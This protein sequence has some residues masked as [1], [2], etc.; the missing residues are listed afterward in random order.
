MGG[1]EARMSLSDV[2]LLS[3]MA[4][5]MHRAVRATRAATAIKALRHSHRQE[6][7]AFARARR[8]R[9]PLTVEGY[10]FANPAHA[11]AVTG[12][13]AEPPVQVS[14]LQAGAGLPDLR[15]RLVSNA[16]GVPLFHLDVRQLQAALR[17]EAGRYLDATVSATVGAG[18]FNQASRPAL[19]RREPVIEEVPLAVA[20]HRDE[21]GGDAAG[22][23]GATG[24]TAAEGGGDGGAGGGGWGQGGEKKKRGVMEAQLSLPEVMDV[25]V[26]HAMVSAVRRKA[27]ALSKDRVTT[28]ARIRQPFRM[29]NRCGEAL[30]LTVRRS[31][32]MT[33]TAAAAKEELR[34]TLADGGEDTV[35][36]GSLPAEQQPPAAGGGDVS[37]PGTPARS[38]S[39]A[40]TASPS[41]LQQVQAPCWE[42]IAS[43]GMSERRHSLMVAMRHRGCLYVS[44]H[45]CP[46]DTAGAHSMR[47]RRM[48]GSTPRARSTFEA[49][50]GGG[51]G[52]GG[53]R[54]KSPAA[55]LF[56]VAEVSVDDDGTRVLTVRTR[57][58]IENS[59]GV[60]VRLSLGRP[61]GARVERDLDAGATAHVPLSLLEPDLEIHARPTASAGAPS[62]WATLV[63]SLAGAEKTAYAAPKVK[64]APTSAGG[65]GRAG[66]QGSGGGGGGDGGE[67]KVFAASS[68]P[69]PGASRGVRG[70]AGAGAL[71]TGTGSG[72]GSSMVAPSSWQVEPVFLWV[73]AD[74]SANHDAPVSSVAGGGSVE[75][76]DHSAAVMMAEALRKSSASSSFS[77]RLR[78]SSSTSL[79]GYGAALPGSTTASP[80]HAR[81]GNGVVDVSG[82]SDGDESSSSL[83]GDG[84]GMAPPTPV[85]E[86]SALQPWHPLGAPTARSSPVPDTPSPR[87]RGGDDL[88][89]SDDGDTFSDDD[90]DD[91]EDEEEKGF[92]QARQGSVPATAEAAVQSSSGGGAT[93]EEAEKRRKRAV[94]LK[95]IISVGGHSPVRRL[96]SKGTAGTSL[97]SHFQGGWSDSGQSGGPEASSSAPAGAGAVRAKTFGLKREIRGT[98]LENVFKEMKEETNGGEGGS[99]KSPV[100]TPP[101]S[102]PPAENPPAVSLRLRAPLVLHNLLCAPM[103]YRVV[104]R[105][106]LLSAEGVLPVGASVALHRVDLCQKQY[107]SFL[108]VNYPWSD[109]IKVHSPTSAHPLREKV[110]TVEVRGVKVSVPGEESSAGSSSSSS[111]SSKKGRELPGLHLHVALQARHNLS[112]FCR[113]WLVNRTEMVLQHRD[114]SLAGG[115]DS[116]FMGDRMPQITQPGRQ[117]TTGAEGGGGGVGVV[118]YRLHRSESV[119]TGALTPTKGGDGARGG[120]VT[121]PPRSLARV[122]TDS[123]PLR[124]GIAGSGGGKNTAPSFPTPSYASLA[125]PK[126]PSQLG[127]GPPVG[128]V[129]FSGRG[130]GG[131]G[132]K[133]SPSKERGPSP[134][135]VGFLGGRGVRIALTVALPCCH[136]DEVDVEVPASETAEGLLL[137][138]A[139]EARLGPID[140]GEYFLCPLQAPIEDDALALSEIMTWEMDKRSLVDGQLRALKQSFGVSSGVSRASAG[141]ARWD[142]L[143]FV[144][145]DYRPVHPSTLVSN[146][147]TPWLRMCHRAE[148]AA[149]AQASQWL[150]AA[151][152]PGTGLDALAG[153]RPSASSRPAGGRPPA[154]ATAAAG[155]V[156]DKT[157]SA[158][159]GFFAAIQSVSSS[160]GSTAV[161]PG[162][163]ARAAATGPKG[164]SARL[165]ETVKGVATLAEWGPAVM[166]GPVES[167]DKMKLCS[168]VQDSEWCSSVDVAGL[169]TAAGGTACISVEQEK[170]S[171]HREASPRT[172]YDIGIQV[173]PGEG[174]FRRTMVLTL[175]PR[176]VLINALPRT[177]EFTQASC[178]GRWRGVLPPGARR[179]FHWPFAK[180][181]R[182]LNVRFLSESDNDD[183]WIW[184]GDL[185]LDTVGEVAVKLR[186]ATGGGGGGGPGKEYITRVKLALVGASVTAVFERQDLRWPPYRVD[187]LTSLG[188][189]YRQA[190][191]SSDAS[192]VPAAAEWGAGSSGGRRKGELPWDGLGPQAAAPFTWDQPI[193]ESRVL[194]VGFAQAGKWEE[195]EYRLDELEKHKRVSLTRTLPSLENPRLR[196]EMLQ[197]QTGTLTDVWRRRWA[198]LKGPVLFLFKDKGCVHLR[199]AI[200]LGATR[201]TGDQGGGG[202]RGGAAGPQRAQIGQKAGGRHKG[203]I[204]DKMGNMMDDAVGLLVGP[205]FVSSGGGEAGVVGGMGMAGISATAVTVAAAAAAAAAKVTAT[206]PGSGEGSPSAAAAG[207]GDHVRSGAAAAVSAMRADEALAL[208]GMMWKHMSRSES[209]QATWGLDGG[210]RRASLSQSLHWVEEGGATACVP[211]RGLPRVP[212]GL[213]AAGGRPS[214]GDPQQPGGGSVSEGGDGTRNTAG[215]RFSGTTSAFRQGMTLAEWSTMLTEM[216]GSGHSSET[217]AGVS[218]PEAEWMCRQLVELGLLV[219]L[220]STRQSRQHAGTAASVA[221]VP[222]TPRHGR[223]SG[224]TSRYSGTQDEKM[225]SAVAAAAAAAGAGVLPKDSPFPTPSSPKFGLHPTSESEE[226]GERDNGVEAGRSGQER[227][228]LG[229]MGSGLRRPESQQMRNMSST[230]PPPGAAGRRYLLRDPGRDVDLDPDGTG[231]V[232]VLSA[233]GGKHDLRCDSAPAALRWIEAMRDAVDADCVEALKKSGRATPAGTGT[234]VAAAAASAE[235]AERSS[236]AGTGGGGDVSAPRLEGGE[237]IMSRLRAK[238]YVN[239]RVRADGPTKVLELVEEAGEEVE[240]DDGAVAAALGKTGRESSGGGP[241]SEGAGTLAAAAA[242]ADAS[243]VTS[244][245]MLQMA[246]IGVSLVDD[247]PL[248]LLYFLACGI[249]ADITATAR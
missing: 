7:L 228:G 153:S 188:I 148:L 113:L 122:A 189:R 221:G 165:S 94:A 187:N 106:G 78:Q 247:R 131:G 60:S 15:L 82:T 245:Y 200:Y 61:G 137:A 238:V 201:S 93:A 178:G 28:G 196:G 77:S 146:L 19:Y 154:R 181:R 224:G 103:L 119:G 205:E 177:L 232:R 5:S 101:S 166:F 9:N 72:K 81:V 27:L 79:A 198:V 243:S 37:Q 151:L 70:F 194:T 67:Y 149:A 195:R 96:A 244:V 74:V 44:S 12:P 210:V 34:F 8:D 88:V 71:G 214:T 25:N 222:G 130:A 4:R 192:R 90:D 168:R 47:M 65:G 230:D 231:M 215:R 242:A 159:A 115:I 46:V 97:A 16:L 3:S 20:V 216:G 64:S 193:G 169:K 62:D 237:A 39:R 11:V 1:I 126:R 152:P 241:E 118:D 35:D 83:E 220:P 125:S 223:T 21:G 227:G 80:H 53:G 156:G 13:H 63:K 129:G 38:R 139:A 22:K 95:E 120:G 123:F 49:G 142:R 87:R 85:F 172:R 18:Y 128:G 213:G 183:E 42:P 208:G 249:K 98:K 134:G 217:P 203:D 229:R 109:F 174:D 32:G 132:G 147:G 135:G 163:A 170:P 58:S 6:M 240:D 75:S 158:T 150:G 111:S 76:G 56:L 29:R 145:D 48:D 184:S 226:G 185:K 218:Y 36:F 164:C 23:E 202:A 173:G 66:V 116:T 141:Y 191:S 233:A 138:V 127:K 136:L 73:L 110:R 204:L 157:P 99:G 2:K 104:N 180:D 239:V 167:L 234:A 236:S 246:G 171:S 144:F 112:V 30:A 197:R 206:F 179:A 176:Y 26:T 14:M 102:A 190:L 55:V 52:G 100:P 17:H 161:G 92:H 59:C 212:S 140:P 186:A 84:S 108:L 219:P 107:A 89:L 69:A 24:A 33:T 31:G 117:E 51:S 10:A 175:L 91:D 211:G 235:A 43:S 105:Q 41:S 54:D 45:G 86:K 248:E 124:G 160:G 40:T 182:A 50:R 155:T 209:P 114:S 225:L 162:A 207:G 143:G 199:G 57:V 68:A 133:A 121:P